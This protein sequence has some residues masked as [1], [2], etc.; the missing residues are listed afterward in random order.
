MTVS[1]LI[2]KRSS[3]PADA[4]VTLLYPVGLCMGS[5]GDPFPAAV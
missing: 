4:R 2:A 3:Y 5:P 1:D